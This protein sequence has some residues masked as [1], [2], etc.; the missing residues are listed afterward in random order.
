MFAGG[1]MGPWLVSA[2]RD[3]DVLRLE[4]ASRWHGNPRGRLSA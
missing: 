1:G 3:P 2:Q 4:N